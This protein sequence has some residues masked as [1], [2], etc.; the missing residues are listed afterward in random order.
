MP[1]SKGDTL[2]AI[3]V[4][5][6]RKPQRELEETESALRDWLLALR[7]ASPMSD[8]EIAQA[9]ADDRR[10]VQRWVNEGRVPGGDVTVRLLGALGVKMA[11]EPPQE[12]HAVNQEI[13]DLRGLLE[14]IE[15]M[16]LAAHSVQAVA[17][18]DDRI[19]DISARL[20]SLEERVGELPTAKD[21]GAAVSTLQAAIQ[22]AATADSPGARPASEGIEKAL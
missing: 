17:V 15:T 12:L 9:I 16:L 14:R 4:P 1:L 3:C 8:R 21:L 5:V 13:A 19:D 10:N 2:G 11:P 18:D 6:P 22:N 7:N 20:R